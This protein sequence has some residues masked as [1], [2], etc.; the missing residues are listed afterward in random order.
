MAAPAQLSRHLVQSTAEA[1]NGWVAKLLAREGVS[2]LLQVAYLG[3]MIADKLPIVPNRIAPGPLLGRAAFGIIAGGALAQLH[4]DSR[5][6]GVCVGGAAAVVGAYA[7]YYARRALVHELGL[8]DL[9]VA[10]CEDVV[11]FLLAHTALRA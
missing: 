1:P 6:R 4:G 9:P 3:E 2:A 7:G 8:P 5:A 10:L 11:A